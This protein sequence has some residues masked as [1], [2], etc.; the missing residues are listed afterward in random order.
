MKEELSGV[1]SADA[2]TGRA[3][4]AL[5]KAASKGKGSLSGGS[6]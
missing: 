1:P 3:D 6:Q 2:L 5:G 4:T